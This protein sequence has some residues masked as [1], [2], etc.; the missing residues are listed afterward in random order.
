MT[1][2]TVDISEFTE[3]GQDSLA[4]YIR[5][6]LIEKARALLKDTSE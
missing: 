3:T 2:Y 1:I 5:T 4:I 6:V